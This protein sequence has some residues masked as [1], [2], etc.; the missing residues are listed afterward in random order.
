MS[1][2]LSETDPAS[3]R[4]VEERARRLGLALRRV[5]GGWALWKPSPEDS[6]P[7]VARCIY[8]GPWSG[9][10][11]TLDRYEYG[12]WHKRADDDRARRWR[13]RNGWR[14]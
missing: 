6:D 3:V 2:R 10:K 13:E 9:V 12:D 1:P 4:E 14:G 5:G 8:G 11:A 7:L